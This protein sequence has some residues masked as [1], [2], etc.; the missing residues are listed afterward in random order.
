M[1]RSVGIVGVA[2]A[3]VVSTVFVGLIG[4][5]HSEPAAQAGTATGGV[6]AQAGPSVSYTFSDFFKVPYGE[7]WD[8]R[9]GLYG[10]RAIGADCFNATSIKDKICVDKNGDG[11]VTAESGPNYMNWYPSPIV[12]QAARANPTIYAPFRMSVVASGIPNYTVTNP[13]MLPLCTDL[14]VSITGYPACPST[15]PAG[16]SISMQ[17]NFQYLDKNSATWVDNTCGTSTFAAEDG[18]ISMNNIS[19]TIDLATASRIFGSPTSSVSAA[20]SWWGTYT[21][22]TCLNQKVVEAGFANW[23]ENLGGSNA[24]FGPYDVWSA[25]QYWYSPFKTNFV[26]SVAPNGVTTVNIM[27]VTWAAEALLARWFFWGPTQYATNVNDPTKARG[28]WGMELPWFEDFHMTATIAA[29]TSL[30]FTTVVQYGFQQGA[31]PGVDGTWGTA[32]DMPTWLWQSVLADYIQPANGAHPYSELSLYSS[33]TYLHTQCGSIYYGT[34][35]SYDYR[36]QN[37]MIKS[38]ETLTF[39]FPTG[40]VPLCDLYA[41]PHDGTTG[42][43]DP[44][45]LVFKSGPIMPIDTVPT[46]LGTWDPSTNTLTIVGPASNSLDPIKPLYGA[47]WI[48][49]GPPPLLRVTTNPAVPGKISVDGVA[50]DEWGLTWVKIAPGTHT[51]SFGGLN[52]LGTPPDQTVSTSAGA[53]T[54]VKGNYVALGYLRVITSPA[55]PS[56]ISVNG[57]PR[58]DWGMWTALPVG[59][60][61]VHFGLVAGYN[62]PADQTATVTAGTTQTVTG[63]FTLSSGAPGPDPTTFGYLRVTTNPAT[64]AQILVN[65]V[66]RD[67]WG[68]TWVKLAP[69]TYT[70]SFGQGYGYTPPAPQMFT[71]TAGATTTWDAPFVAHGSLRVTTNP[72]LPATIFVNGVPRDDWGMWQSMPPGTY[73]VSFGA[74]PGFTAPAA[75]TVTVTA[76]VLTPVTG[77]YVAGPLIG[78]FGTSGVPIAGLPI[79]SAAAAPSSVGGET[80]TLAAWTRVAGA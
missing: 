9:L 44:N 5:A 21:D 26:V 50:R 76:G 77:S 70:V 34:Q 36:P 56:T 58:N 43:S 45:T 20:Q 74:V 48:E 69:G 31:T 3:L 37:W 64:A 28:W 29:T 19:L 42:A 75:Q 23:A 63:T 52:G 16:T 62:P 53:T 73:T 66:P 51:V 55:V 30:S 1:R 80:E 2:L 6:T 38:G 17:W 72:A 61:T 14:A 24:K 32:D 8:M 46:P 78:Q 60:Y 68:L 59:T 39:H 65:G 4:L 7:W 27:H 54:V 79:V 12:I 49:L 35:F 18:F 13:V 41:S 40:N 15:L 47:P 71:V 11:I 10:D 25:Y 67:D 33:N 57:V 22:P